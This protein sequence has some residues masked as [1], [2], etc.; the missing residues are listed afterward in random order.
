MLLTIQSN[1]WRKISDG[2]YMNS[3][4][5]YISNVTSISNSKN[6]K[7][8]WLIF[9]SGNFSILNI[10]DSFSENML[11]TKFREYIF[12]WITPTKKLSKDFIRA[13]ESEYKWWSIKVSPRPTARY[14]LAVFS[15]STLLCISVSTCIHSCKTR[16][17]IFIIDSSLFFCKWTKNLA[18]VK[19]ETS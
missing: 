17:S 9:P 16:L 11:L 12:K 19:K 14:T 8:N 1:A 6:N 13:T 3:N 4:N 5:N 10:T 7:P 2:D 18:M 15:L